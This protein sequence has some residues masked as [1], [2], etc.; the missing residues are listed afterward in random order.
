MKTI[1]RKDMAVT[2]VYNGY[3]F[4]ISEFINKKAPAPIADSKANRSP[5]TNLSNDVTILI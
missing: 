4:L 1:L 5:Y 2:P 3:W